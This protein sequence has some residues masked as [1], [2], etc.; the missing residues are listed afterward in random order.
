MGIRCFF[1]LHQWHYTTEEEMEA[2]QDREL[3]GEIPVFGA[4]DRICER[5]GQKQGYVHAVFK[6]IPVDWERL[7]REAEEYQEELA[8]EDEE[9]EARFQDA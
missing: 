9:I 4:Y 7:R 8:R 3:S 5:C 6:Y 1:E 2:L